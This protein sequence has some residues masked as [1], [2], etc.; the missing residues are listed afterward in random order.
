MQIH[1]HVHSSHPCYYAFSIASQ[2]I[3]GSNSAG[4]SELAVI[5]DPDGLI[6]IPSITTKEHTSLTKVLIKTRV[7]TNLFDYE[8]DDATIEVTGS[9]TIKL[10]GSRVRKLKLDDGVSGG[11]GT[12]R[13]LQGDASEQEATFDLA[14]KLDPGVS[15]DEEGITMNSALSVAAGSSIAGFI[16]FFATAITSW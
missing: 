6:L 10:K 3:K 5:G 16:V 12:N 14:I 2:T 15:G 11:V 9:L 1:F 7:P 4:N 8:A 13:K